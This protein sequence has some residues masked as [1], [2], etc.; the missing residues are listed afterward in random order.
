MKNKGTDTV[1]DRGIRLEH[2]RQALILD[3]RRGICLVSRFDHYVVA[4]T[5]FLQL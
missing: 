4:P 1:Y 3:P 5:P 2:R